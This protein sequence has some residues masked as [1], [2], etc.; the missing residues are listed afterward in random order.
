M[1]LILKQAQDTFT[2]YSTS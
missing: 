1:D 2:F